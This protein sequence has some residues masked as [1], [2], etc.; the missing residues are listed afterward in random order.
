MHNYQLAARDNNASLQPLDRISPSMA[1][2]TQ[3]E[4]ERV[5][6]Q[7]LVVEVHEQI[8]AVLAN[9]ALDNVGALSALEAHLIEIAPLGEARYKHIVDAYALGASRVITRW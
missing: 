6:S 9:T 4:V 5:I 7:G 2:K 1:R 8:R 3:R